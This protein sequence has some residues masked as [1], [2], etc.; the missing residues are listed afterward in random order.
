MQHNIFNCFS[1]LFFVHVAGRSVHPAEGLAAADAFDKLR[2]VRNAFT[3]IF[4]ASGAAALIYEVTWTRL[5]TLQVGHGLAAASTVLAAF[6]GGLAVGSAVAGRLSAALSP[7]RALRVYAVLELTIG[8]LAL[9]LPFELAAL[10]PLLANAY[11]DGAGGA[12]FTSLRI[13]ASL[14]LL[15]LPAAAMGATFPAASRWFIHSA[16]AAA[17]DAGVMYA[18]NTIGA[19]MGALAAG[20]VLLPALGLSGATWIGVLLNVTAA[21]GAWL[22]SGRSAVAESERGA[23]SDVSPTESRPPSPTAKAGATKGRTK[24]PPAAPPAPRVAR[25]GVAAAALGISGFASL[26]LQVV[27]TRLLALILGPTTYA[28]SMMVAVFVAG[29]AI[30]AGVASRAAA[31]AREPLL[32]LAVCLAVSVGCGASAA[33]FVDRG[34]LAIAGVIAQPDIPFSG[35][36]ARQ[37]LLAIALLAPMTIAFGAAFPFAIAVGTRRDDTVTEDL[38]L[39][40]AVNT[41][42]A[43]TGAL[44]AGFVLI[45]GIGLHGT[46]RAVTIAGAT[47][48]A[49]LL[50]M[51][52]ASL[53]ARGLAGAVIVLVAGLGVALPE[54]DRLLLSSGGYKYA[55]VLQAPD[56]RTGLT[57]GEL[58]YYGEGPS[59]TVAVRRTGGTMSLAIDGKVD[60]S[61][62]G[63]ML[64][65]RL[66]AHVPLLLHPDPRKLAILGLGSG[67]TLGSALTHP[68][69]RADLLEISPQVVEASR[70]FDAENH[71]ALADPRTRLIVGDG[72]TH[73]LLTRERYDVIVSEPSNPW[74]A[75]IAS[76]FTREFF[77]A[78]RDRLA[79][80]GV[81]C[82][83]AHTYDISTSD[84]QSIV[85]TF[86]SVFPDATLWLI[87]DGDVLLVGSNAPLEPR[88]EHVG[89]GWERPAVAADL[90][91]VG[92]TGPFQVL[93]LFVAHGARLAQWAADAPIQS[94]NRAA[95]EFSGPASAL[96]RGRADNAEILRGIAEGAGARPVAVERALATATSDA[97]RDRGLMM[98]KADASRPAYAD[99]VRAIDGNPNDERALEGLI[100]ASAQL[101][102]QTDTG[103]LLARLASDPTH[104]PAKVIMSRFLASQGQYDQAVG[105]MM[106][107]LQGDPG[108]VAAL[109]QLASVLSDLGDIERMQPVV[110]RLRAEA[111]SSEGAH[112]YSAALLFMEN[113][114]ALALTEAERVLAT[115]PRHAQANNLLGACLASLGQP[116]R[117]RA[118][119]QASIE[120]NPKD[121]APYS[122]LATLELQSGNRDRAARYFAEAL[123]IDPTSES[124]RRGLAE[125]ARN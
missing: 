122:N 66:L 89:A 65:Q 108:N 82:Q 16:R 76:L 70:F 59:G 3:A 17:R 73:L 91:S 93:S 36:L 40:Y 120:A 15:S 116:D 107:V 109:E 9:A 18:A 47:G 103:A 6:M 112:Y 78:A 88:L 23:G 12:A 99:F 79:P 5:L 64:T 45:P 96:G 97:W 33:A 123:T 46:I 21:G 10:G 104:L 44:V 52:G 53:R 110:A 100:E 121:P 2:A 48:A 8:V 13:V 77:E 118:A 37:A 98:L 125:I 34:I 26:T 67:V 27:W 94:D 117:A 86:A 74:M 72:R 24:R 106:G 58:L 19:A 115:N 57:A 43:I 90:A 63:D 101:R 56:L 80:G 32:G 39:I 30:G 29:L 71:R 11:A 105:I 31:R 61:N 113:R 42:G 119:F 1:S 95:L 85:A 68:V 14:L 62:S 102:R 114:T 50:L 92:V 25:P 4:A 69:E 54:W 55:A 75:G 111:P 22:I 124:A 35:V 38:G 41:A 83:W 20:F 49:G 87:G 81:L 60:A 28:F 84:L 51:S 7:A